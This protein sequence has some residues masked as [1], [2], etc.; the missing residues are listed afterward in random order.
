MSR[1]K[2]IIGGASIGYVH[3]AAIVALGLW[4]TP[5]VLHHV[6]QHEYGLWLVA[7]QLMGYLTLL[8][9]G[10]LAILPREVAFAS[11][12]V[13]AAGTPTDRV[14]RLVAQVRAIVRWQLPAL[15][16]ACAAVWWWLPA[17]WATLRWPLI[18]VFVAF[19]VLYPLRVES[20]ALQ[21][22]QDHAFLAKAQMAGWALG[23]LTTVVLVLTNFGLYAL[24]FGWIVGL[25]TPAAAGWWRARRLWAALEAPGQ[26]PPPNG[27]FKRSIWVSI[28]QVSQ[29]L[30]GGSDVLILGAI[31][32][33]AAVVAYACTGK[34]VTVLANHPQ[35]LMH[36]AQ[37]ALTEL[38]AS[39]SKERIR[40]VATALTQAMLI[41]SGGLVVAILS[42]NHY[43]VVRWVGAEQ[44][45]GWGLSLAFTA[46]MLL[47]HWNV[48]TIY[49]LFCFGYERQLSLTGLADGI[50]TIAFT[51]LG[52]WQWGAI[53]APIGSIAGVVLVSLPLNMRSV[54]H[55]MGLSVGGFLGSVS[56]LLLRIVG[57]A[58]A[59][60]LTASSRL[61]QSFGGVVL[62]LVLA[63]TV[64]AVLIG[65]LALNGPVAPYLRMAVPV[66]GRFRSKPTVDHPVA[67]ESPS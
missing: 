41:M 10:V 45:G 52:V 37:P 34:L 16:V 33:P 14:F 5:F 22:I 48:A 61:E 50:V 4:L 2:R 62:L 60:A 39:E 49:T 40:T 44:Y 11:G 65:P 35:L 20:A 55:E 30:L 26:T 43:F 15:A 12:D 53:G 47:R 19:V 36:A 9:L 25:A 21:G 24:A 27:Y 58:A 38:R 66:L 17:E 13:N 1:T 8:D 28:G 57:L 46:M 18:P 6:G 67:A 23:S 59:A 51:A 54:A 56:T 64:F 31:L 63:G 42:V 7:G 29:V 32:G 3:Q